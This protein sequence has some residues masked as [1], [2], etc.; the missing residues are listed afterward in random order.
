[1]Q[2]DS[3]A[4]LLETEADCRLGETMAGTPVDQD[5]VK[6]QSALARVQRRPAD[7]SPESEFLDLVTQGPINTALMKTSGIDASLRYAFGPVGALGQFEVAASFSQVLQNDRLEFE[8][9]EIEDL[10]DNRAW[11]DWHSRMSGEFSWN[12]GP[13]AASLFVQRYGHI[14]NWAETARL[15]AYLLTNLSAR[16]NGLMNGEAYVGFAIQNLF[17]RNPPR[18]DTWDQ[19]PYYSDYNYSPVGREVFVEVGLRF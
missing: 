1:V 17:D 15:P 13:F 14:W 19:Y 5:S 12:K 7:G 2:D 9:D 10:L 4:L 11:P 18:D 3:L 6:C 16:Y 8:G